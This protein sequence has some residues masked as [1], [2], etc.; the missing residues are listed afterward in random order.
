[1]QEH[2][3]QHKSKCYK[4]IDEIYVVLPQI[5]NE[6]KEREDEKEEKCVV[7]L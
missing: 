6:V 2:L 1:M 4:V 7:S 5:Y 3:N